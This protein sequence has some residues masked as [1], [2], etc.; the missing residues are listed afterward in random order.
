MAEL[1]PL[2]AAQ[3]EVE[4]V[5]G[6]LK[7]NMGK[8]LTVSSLLLKLNG[9]EWMEMNRVA[10]KI[11]DLYHNITTDYQVLERDGKVSE[12]DQ[13]TDALQVDFV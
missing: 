1:T 2:A 4:E 9:R 7:D 11:G 6:I 5:S 13:R 10:K 3:A 12:L 8:V